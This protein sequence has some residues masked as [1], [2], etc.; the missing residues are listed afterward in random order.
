MRTN[1]SDSMTEF[2]KSKIEL[3]SM[4]K[5]YDASENILKDKTEFIKI[6]TP[7][8][9]DLNKK[10]DKM[11]EKH[12]GILDKIAKTQE[13][14]EEVEKLINDKDLKDLKDKTEGVEF[15]IKRLQTNLM[16]ANNDVNELN[17]QI[18]FHINLIET[19]NEE[20]TSIEK[21]NVKLE[22]DKV[23]Y[24]EEIEK[25]NEKIEALKEQIAVI[26][27]K[28]GKLLSERDEI[29]NDLIELEK[30]KHIKTSDIERIAEQIESF[31]AR[32][33]ELEPQM[34]IAREELEK[35]GVEI[36]K[37]EPVNISIDEI[38]SKIQ[39]L[40]RR[41]EELGDV[42]MRALVAYEE[43][44]ARQEELKLQIETLSKERKEILERMQGYEQLK[45]ETF[46]KTYNN[47]NE[48]FK[49]MFHS[50]SEGEGELVL[51]QPEDPLSGGLDMKVS[52]RD[53]KHQR[54]GS[55]SG[56]E[57]SLTA[58]AFVFA[59]QRYMPAPFYAFDEVDASLDTMNVERIAQMV[60]SQ[61]KNTQF[62]VVSHRKPMIESAN[63]TIGVTQKEKG[64][65]RVTGIKLRDEE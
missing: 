61:S 40:E 34:D 19:K 3:D 24:K 47:I 49:E 62:I 35:S 31:K 12:I 16:N 37:L 20:I 59:I 13:Q 42:N 48:N 52:I 22:E 6:T 4:N 15:E 5:N 50:L 54:L 51:E 8:I 10:L 56:G 63:R 2:S 46:M 53:K 29:N 9:E 33:R 38:T 26:E 36:N 55:L 43:V 11:E 17:R 1:Y 41:M 44:L 60:Q 57:K 45:K 30:Q 64:I 65:T 14:I 28:L 23:R 21:N 27:E 32:R 25:L 18:T 39:R 58:L 7:K